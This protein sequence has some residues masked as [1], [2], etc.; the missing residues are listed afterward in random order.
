M[1]KIVHRVDAPFISGPVVIETLDAVQ[2]RVAHV[3]VGRRHIDAGAALKT[4]WEE[5]TNYIVRQGGDSCM[6]PIGSQGGGGGVGWECFTC[7]DPHD[8]ESVDGTWEFFEATTKAEKENGWGPGME[9]A[10]SVARGSDGRATPEKVRRKMLSES[11]QPGVFN[12]QWK[13][14]QIFDPNNLGDEY[15]KTLE[16]VEKK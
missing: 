6:S 10:Q 4:E 3:H 2:H 14:R 12:Y 16:K 5:K 11:P 7:F 8:K 1:R 9:R 13:I 15:Y